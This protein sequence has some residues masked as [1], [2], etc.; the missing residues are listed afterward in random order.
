MNVPLIPEYTKSDP[1]IGVR[2]NAMSLAVMDAIV[3]E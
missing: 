2:P 3:S 1:M